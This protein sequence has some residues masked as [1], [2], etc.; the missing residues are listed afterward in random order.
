MTFGQPGARLLP[1][2]NCPSRQGLLIQCYCDSFS[3]TGSRHARQRHLQ[4]GRF[5]SMAPGGSQGGMSVFAG[6]CPLCMKHLRQQIKCLLAGQCKYKIIWRRASDANPLTV[7]KESFLDDSRIM[8]EHEPKS[9][10]WNLLIRDV[11]LDDAGVYECQVSSKLR[12]LRHH[13]LLEVH[14]IQISGSSVV[15]KDDRIYLICNATGLGYPPDDLDWFIEG[16]KLTTSADDKVFI[17]K[18]VSLTDKTIVS[19]LEIRDAELEDSGVYTCRASDLQV[20]S[21]RVTVLNADT[22]NVKRGTGRGH[23]SGAS[24]FST[25]SL[26]A[27]TK[28]AQQGLA[29][30]ILLALVRLIQSLMIQ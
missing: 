28:L 15:D 21:M 5:F 30:A 9:S 17:R 6:A 8:L 29:S 27:R 10:S 23:S 24:F 7:G 1:V 13:V 16:N 4:M 26:G 20:R 11:R 25:K 2:K 12:H 19:I 18:F 3:C 14:A 22:Y